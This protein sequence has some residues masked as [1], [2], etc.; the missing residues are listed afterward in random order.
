MLG[1][2]PVVVAA[3]RF[4]PA[5]KPLI[6]PV[7]QTVKFTVCGS[8]IKPGDMVH[9]TGTKWSGT[10]RCVSAGVFVPLDKKA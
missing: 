6:Y 5:A 1:M 9:V 7:T 2:A 8:S 10:Y 4:L 3:A